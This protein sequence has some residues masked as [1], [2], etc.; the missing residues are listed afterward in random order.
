MESS[1]ATA[2][3]AGSETQPS[4]FWISHR[5]GI[6]ADC[7]RPCGY[8]EIHHC[9]CLALSFENSKLAGWFG[10]RRRTLKRSSL[11][12]VDADDLGVGDGVD[13]RDLEGVAAGRAADPLMVDHGIADDHA[14][15]QF[16]LVL[17]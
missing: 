9:A 17:R 3:M 5:I 10:E 16:G 7:W 12:K 6:T 4:C 15:E 2:R 11:H 8:F 13:G 1:A 14:V